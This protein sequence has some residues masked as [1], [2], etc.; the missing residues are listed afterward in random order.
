MKVI[1]N[2][3]RGQRIFKCKK[4]NNKTKSR[5]PL[6]IEPIGKSWWF[7]L[8]IGE[9][10]QVYDPNRYSVS[11]YYSMIHDGYHNVYSLKSAKRLIYKWNVPKGTWF[12]VSLPYIGYYFKIKK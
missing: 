11:S 9:W 12:K 2:K 4:L 6:W 7:D 8:D 3:P 5:R 10:Y 1:S